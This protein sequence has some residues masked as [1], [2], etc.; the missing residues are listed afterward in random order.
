MSE[1][2]W[3]DQDRR[4]VDTARILA[5]DAVQ[6]AGNGHPGTAISLAGVAYLLYQKVMNTDPSDEHWIG[7]DRFVL[8]AGHASILQYTQLFLGGLG[9]EMGD[10]Q[11]LRTYGSKTPGHPEL[12]HTRFVECTTGP[13]GAGI[14]NAVGM[15]M[16]ARR[17]RGLYD[18]DATAGSVFDHFV[19]VIAGDGCMQEGVQAEAA[20]LAGTQELGN[21]GERGV[22]RR[23]RPTAPGRSEGNV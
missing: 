1:L 5:A 3:T 22:R 4:A 12:G 11:A 9:L 21:H 15:A 17:N 6:R 7:R 10:I 14:S 13:L 20:S 16:A 23:R 18:P 2:T 19:Y 8:S